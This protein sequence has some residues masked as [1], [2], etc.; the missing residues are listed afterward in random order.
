[1]QVVL[2]VLLTQVPVLAIVVVGDYSD[3]QLLR[4]NRQA[5]VLRRYYE[6]LVDAIVAHQDFG[7][8]YLV[9]A[10]GLKAG[11]VLGEDRVAVSTVRYWHAQYVEGN[12]VLRPDERGHHSR[13]L[14]I[15]EEDI[16]RKFIKWSLR[17]AKSDDLSIEAA[18]EF[19]N[20]DLLVSLEV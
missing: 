19:L 2:V 15:N 11:Q 9:T 17:Q 12:G 13:E 1:M 10:L 4:V 6:L 7:V 14:L 8:T 3:A 5:L 16:Q 20:T 18:R